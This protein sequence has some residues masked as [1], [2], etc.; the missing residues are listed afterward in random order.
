MAGNDVEW[1]IQQLA[2]AAE[3]LTLDQRLRI[4]ALL[5]RP[6]QPEAGAPPAPRQADAESPVLTVEEAAKLLRVGRTTVYDLI[7]NG[8]LASVRM[9]RL[10]RIRHADLADYLS[11][12][13]GRA[14]EL[15]RP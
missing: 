11:D 12:L 1:A 10:R 2:A 5:A 3:S 8:R 6:V 13:A 7:R 14:G 15:P 4:A 9:G